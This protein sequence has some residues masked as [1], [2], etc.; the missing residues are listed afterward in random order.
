VLLTGITFASGMWLW[1]SPLVRDYYQWRVAGAFTHQ[2]TQAADDCVAR[3][4]ETSLVTISGLPSDFDDG[5]EDTLLLAVTLLQDYTV[6]SAL[7]LH[8]PDRTFD[9]TASS[10]QTLRSS[11]DVLRISCAANGKSM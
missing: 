9:V 4:P 6:Q 1:T 5:R 11:S 8:F 3:S 10:S 2:Y 7:Q